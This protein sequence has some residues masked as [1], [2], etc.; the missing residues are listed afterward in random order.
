M[1][2]VRIFYL[3]SIKIQAEIIQNVKQELYTHC[4]IIYYR[5][6]YL[7]TFSELLL[8]YPCQDHQPIKYARKILAA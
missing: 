6:V 5:S 2:C 8:Y 1:M 4:K 7:R 3:Q